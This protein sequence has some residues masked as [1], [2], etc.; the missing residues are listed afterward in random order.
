MRSRG[1]MTRFARRAREAM[2]GPHDAPRAGPGRARLSAASRGLA[3]DRCLKLWPF[4]CGPRKEDHFGSSRSGTFTAVDSARRFNVVRVVE[5]GHG[6]D[7]RTACAVSQLLD[8]RHRCSS[9]FGQ[10][11]RKLAGS[12]ARPP[13]RKE[14]TTA[15]RRSPFSQQHEDLAASYRPGDIRLSLRCDCRLGPEPR[16][17]PGGHRR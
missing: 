8:G 17:V 3:R 11:V 4:G 15:E 6:R 13:P 12:R 9:P 14:A 16:A 5:V 1:A 7:S 10:D 2:W